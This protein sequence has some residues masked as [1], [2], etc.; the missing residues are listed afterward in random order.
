MEDTKVLIRVSPVPRQT[1]MT[2]LTER[3]LYPNIS[4]Y[5]S[6]F[7]DKYGKIKTGLNVEDAKRLGEATGLDLTQRSEFWHDFSIRLTSKDL[8]L[9]PTDP[10]DEIKLKLLLAHPE[11]A[12][13]AADV[14]PKTVF[15]IY[16]EIEE[17]EKESKKFDYI[18]EAY[19]RIADMSQV[20]RRDFLKLFGLT[21]ASKNM[22]PDSIKTRLKELADTDAKTFCERFDDKHKADKIFIEDLVDM[23]IL[24]KNGSAYIYNDD[25]LGGNLELTIEFLKKPKNQPTL[26]ALKAQLEEKNKFN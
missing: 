25:V 5:I 24:R 14:T 17:A 23:N 10:L 20:E 19:K 2:N 15:V 18:I 1:P 12:N 16:N 22:V 9:D 7:F 6:P 21:R 4:K 8:F 26:I 13:S 3:G 11:V